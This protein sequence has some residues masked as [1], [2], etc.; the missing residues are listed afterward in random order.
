MNPKPRCRNY[1]CLVLI[2]YGI[3][4]V[5]NKIFMKISPN[6]SLKI[7]NS[8]NPMDR[9]T[10]WQIHGGENHHDEQEHYA[11]H[12][13]ESHEEFEKL[14]REA[15][16]KD[17]DSKIQERAQHKTK[18]SP[19]ETHESNQDFEGSPS[20]ESTTIATINIAE[21]DTQ[22]KLE[23]NTEQTRRSPSKGYLRFRT[24]SVIGGKNASSTSSTNSTITTSCLL[25]SGFV[26]SAI[27]G[28]HWWTTR[29]R[30]ARKPPSTSPYKN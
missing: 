28:I 1:C 4:V 11:I 16:V 13:A 5:L 30:R 10:E 26:F 25:T 8:S 23:R 24:S 6:N 15:G 18:E 19:G 2:L 20:P 17:Q 3:F 27:L 21:Q 7:L 14:L 29:N 22:T 9:N 12:F